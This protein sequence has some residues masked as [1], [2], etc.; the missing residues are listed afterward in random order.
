MKKKV[1]GILNKI[2]NTFK[3]INNKFFFGRYNSTYKYINKKTSLK[4]YIIKFLFSF[5]LIGAFL[6]FLFNN[7]VSAII[8]S[9]VLT[10]FIINE[11]QLNNKKLNYEN[12]ILSELTIYTSQMSLLVSYNNIYSALKEVTTFLSNPVKDD[13]LNVI[14]KIDSGVSI[15]EAFNEFNEK[16]NNRTIT[17]FNQTLE[18]FDSHGD[19]DAST[20]LEVISDEMNMLKV[21]KDKFLRFKKEWRLNFY[22][23][24]VLCLV[25]PLI[26]KAMIP[27]IYNDFMGSFGTI[28]M[29]GIIIM[30]LFVIKKVEMIYRDQ[31]IGEGGYK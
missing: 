29:I 31:S 17:L 27:D 14:S 16:Y 28:V 26:L 12:Y 1:L 6:Y 19:S 5:I 2:K 8:V 25:M 30:K 7:I 24:V 20:V 15:T 21:K 13:L 23:V 4:E 18:L 10:I 22:V 9:F 3:R 11:I